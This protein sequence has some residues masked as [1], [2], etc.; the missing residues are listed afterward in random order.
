[1]SGM[2]YFEGANMNVKIKAEKVG[3]G[4]VI[5][6]NR[7]MSGEGWR[8]DARIALSGIGKYDYQHH[9]L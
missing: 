7:V 9:L 4:V 5:F 1:M 8:R 3:F 6:R 2:N